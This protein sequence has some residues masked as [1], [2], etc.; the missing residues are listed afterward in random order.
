MLFIHYE[1][2]SNIYGYEHGFDCVSSFMEGYKRAAN[3]LK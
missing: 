3:K 1:K 2:P